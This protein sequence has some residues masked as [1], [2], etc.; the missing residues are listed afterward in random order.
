VDSNITSREVIL[1]SERAFAYK[2]KL[3]ALKHQGRTCGTEFHKSRDSVTD[4]MSGR[5]VQKYIRLTELIPELLELV[6]E[7]SMAM[8]PAVEL[9]YLPINEQ[10]AVYEACRNTVS[11]PSHDQTI[12]MRKFSSMGDL[13]PRRINQILNEVKPNQRE[14][15]KLPMDDIS[16]YFP[17]SYTPDRMQKVILKLLESWQRQRQ[18]EAERD[19]R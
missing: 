15:L 17:S 8:R 16:R 1:P 2:M 3:D 19:S 6:D 10:M 14:Q 9:S 7:G 18:R 12:R 4:D 13:I 5:Q 11:T